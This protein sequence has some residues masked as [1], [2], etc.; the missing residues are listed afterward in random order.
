MAE[1]TGQQGYL[2]RLDKVNATARHMLFQ[3]HLGMNKYQVKVCLLGLLR[4]QDSPA[5]CN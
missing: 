5:L 4:T 3:L 2:F 1:Q